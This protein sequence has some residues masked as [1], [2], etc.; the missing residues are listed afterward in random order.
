MDESGPL[1][2]RRLSETTV[3]RSVATI[4]RVAAPR[5]PAGAMKTKIPGR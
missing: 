3:T 4:P 5:A 1:G 2:P